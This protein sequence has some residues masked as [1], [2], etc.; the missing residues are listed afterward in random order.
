MIAKVILTL[1][2]AILTVCDVVAAGGAALVLDD[3]EYACVEAWLLFAALFLQVVEVLSTAACCTVLD[4]VAV[5][6]AAIAPAG[7]WDFP[8]AV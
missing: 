3:V 4:S 8:I 2:V 6:A 1:F 7:R 5:D